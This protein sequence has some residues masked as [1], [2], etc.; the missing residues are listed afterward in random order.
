MKLTCTLIAALILTVNLHSQTKDLGDISVSQL[1]KAVCYLASD[2]L[3]GR[4]PGT[5][6][7]NLAEKYIASRLKNSGLQLFEKNGFQKF[8]IVTGVHLGD[9]NSLSWEGYTG[10]VN[11]DFV[12]F[13]Y[14]GSSR[15]SAGVVFAGYGFDISSNTIIWNDYKNLDVNGKWVLLLRGEPL[16][17]SS[18]SVYRNYSNDLSKVLLAK[19][20]GAAGVI[21]VSGL[22][23]DKN[24]D[25]VSLHSF[26]GSVNIPVIHLKRK[27]A[28]LLLASVNQ[29]ISSLEQKIN[30][31]KKSI[32][33]SLDYVVKAAIS[34]R[35]TIA[36]T[37][38]VIATLSSENPRYSNEF[39]LL[40]AHFDH[41][42]LGG[43]GSSSR[44]PDTI[45]VHNGADDNASGVAAV[46]E[47]ADKFA[48]N[49]KNLKRSLIFVLFSGEEEGILGSRYF[50]DHLP[51]DLKS[52]KTFI[53]LDMVGRLKQ[54]S[55]LEVGGTGTSAGAEQLLKHLA[56]GRALK[57]GFSPEGYGP[58]DHA[59][60]YAK[61]IPVFFFTTGVHLDYHTPFDDAD[62]INYEGLKLVDDYVYSLAWSLATSDSTLKFKE[63]GPKV[64]SSSGRKYKVTLGI[65]PDFASSE[66]KGLKV[67]LVLKD[68]PAERGGMLKGDIITGI[69]GG[70]VTNIQDYMFRLNQLKAGDIVTVKVLRDGNIKELFIKL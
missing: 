6:G 23:F 55:S 22:S 68:K 39:I 48:L 7:D 19:D 70:Q 67:E 36:T 10:S 45:A 38:N 44:R 56:T 25:L 47:L 9:T 18:K 63:S 3:Q 60:F 35:Q 20:K 69:N 50:T 17:D 31:E 8:S 43:P 61:D 24:D 30:N 65:M 11:E 34:V 21:L 54:D 32:T 13:P 41:L 52:V 46:L 12:P 4:F 42:G 64:G 16:I 1:R 53:N 2:S 62:K 14:S 27:A 33:F 49:R 51:V 29:T 37:S 15:L 66:N 40:G 57:L 58:S 5:A 59:A 28:D 26:D